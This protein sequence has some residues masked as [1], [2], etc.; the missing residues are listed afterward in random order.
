[1]R[2]LAEQSGET[3]KQISDLVRQIQQN[4]K[5]AVDAMA[6]SLKSNEGRNYTLM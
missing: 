4:S 3:A 2:K 1:M 5:N 6:E